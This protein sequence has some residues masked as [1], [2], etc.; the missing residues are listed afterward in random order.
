MNFL[1]NFHPNLRFTA[2]YDFATKTV[3][4]LDVLVTVK[5]GQIITDLYRK[6]S[7]AIQYLLPTSCHPGHITRN[8]PYSLA[9]R[10]LRICSNAETMWQRLEELREML[11]SRLYSRT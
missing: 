8:I 11:L 7:S 10:I 4:F 9:Y 5:D 6:P 3:P 2:T 1:N